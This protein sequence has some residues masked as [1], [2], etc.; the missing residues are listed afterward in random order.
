MVDHLDVVAIG[1]EHEGTVVAGVVGAFAGRAVVGATG[2]DRRRVERIDGGTVA[3][4][5]GQVVAAGQ[6]AGGGLAAGTGDEQLVGPEE[7]RPLTPSGTPMVS[8]TAW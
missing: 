2:G 7:V 4:L 8:N 6:L 3:G 5:E 1:V